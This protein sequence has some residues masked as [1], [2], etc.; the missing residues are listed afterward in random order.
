MPTLDWLTRR[1]DEQTAGKTPYRLLEPVPDLS[2]GDT[3]AENQALRKQ[4]MEFGIFHEAGEKTLNAKLDA[5]A[6]AK[7]PEV[8][9]FLL[10]EMDEIVK[11]D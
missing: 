1:E 2:S 6:T 8:Y 3:A 4:L 5:M 7:L 9:E 11:E 10:G